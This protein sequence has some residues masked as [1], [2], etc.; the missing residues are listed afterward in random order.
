MKN[1]Y[2]I[3]T[4]VKNWYVLSHTCEELVRNFHTCEKLVRN[5]HTCEQLVPKAHR[6]K[7]IGTKCS[8]TFPV[9]LKN[10]LPKKDYDCW[11]SFVSACKTLSSVTIT[12]RQ[13]QGH[14]R[15]M[16]F[17]RTFQQLYGSN[18]VT[19]NMHLHSHFIQCIIEFGPMHV[20]WLYSFERM[21]G[22]L[23][24]FHIYIESEPKP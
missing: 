16:A 17:C 14:E 1:S 20:F 19:S 11:M 10:I 7:K 15:F 24:L 23:G 12:T 4:H 2:A 8:Q 18:C 3:F 6:C 21:N 22:T 5:F 13:L 9:A